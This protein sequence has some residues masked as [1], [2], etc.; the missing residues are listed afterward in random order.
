VAETH[1]SEPSKV[2]EERGADPIGSRARALEGKTAEAQA[3]LGGILGRMGLEASIRVVEDDERI[4]L[5]VLGDEAGLVIGKKGQTLDALQYLVNKIVNR[6]REGRKS[7]V[8]DSEGYRGRRADSLVELAHRLGEKA[9]RTRRVITVNPMSPHDRRIIHLA[10]DKV[11][12]VTTRSEGEGS[13]RRL[14]IIPEPNKV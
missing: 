5:D 7:I 3:A 8:V 9:V 11:P 12:G 1:E 6:D 2:V 10:L 4:V 13:F 14:L